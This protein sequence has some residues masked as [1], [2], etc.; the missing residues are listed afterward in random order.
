MEERITVEMTEACLETLIL[1]LKVNEKYAKKRLIDTADKALNSKDKAEQ[2]ECW[3]DVDMLKEVIS[4]M[5]ETIG[6]LRKYI[7]KKSKKIRCN[8]ILRRRA[9]NGMPKS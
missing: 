6:F 8:L 7:P 9:K 5:Q 1:S 3:K 4:E 2:A